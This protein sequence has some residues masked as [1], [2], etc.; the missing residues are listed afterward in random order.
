MAK[1][2]DITPKHY[3]LSLAKQMV[4]KAPGCTAGF[5]FLVNKDN[6]IWYDGAGHTQETLLWVLQRMIFILMNDAEKVSEED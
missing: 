3:P 4:E 6:T 2:T 5:C 1:I